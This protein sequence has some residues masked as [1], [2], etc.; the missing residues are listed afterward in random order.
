MKWWMA[1]LFLSLS[2]GMAF[3]DDFKNS[4][5]SFSLPTGWTCKAEETEFVCTPP[6]LSGQSVSAIMVMTAKIPGPDDNVTAYIDY[7]KSRAQAV[8]PSAMI[9]PPTLRPINGTDWLDCIIEGSELEN[10]MT[11]YLAVSKDGIAILY[12]FS[13]RKDHFDDLVGSAILAV[14]TLQVLDDWK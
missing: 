3:G 9:Q 10:Y 13:A 12:T 1:G 7:L 5:I 2:V 14:S 8:G 6:H 4:Y 11:R